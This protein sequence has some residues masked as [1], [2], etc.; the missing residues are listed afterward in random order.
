MTEI[1]P[2]APNAML[3]SWVGK[4]C[5]E[6]SRQE[7]D[8]TFKFGDIGTVSASC[9][10]RI[11]AEGG[12]A[13]ADEDDGQNFGLLKPIDGVE[14]ATKLLSGRKIVSVEVSPISGD[15]KVHFEGDRV[16]ELFN[17]SSGYEGWQA[18]VTWAGKAF[19]MV[20][21]GGGQISTWTS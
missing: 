16:L 8:W 3:S 10:W 17:N 6:I 2:F 5:D 19:G 18:T 11:L 14:R 9:P 12:I 21:Q 1:E 15:L 13:H 4:T 7:Y 20:A